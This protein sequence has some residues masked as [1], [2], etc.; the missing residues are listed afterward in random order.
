MARN[1]RLDCVVVGYHDIDFNEYATHQRLM[2]KYSGAYRDV[3]H[4]SVLLNGERITYMDLLNH[5]V[6]TATGANPRFN[7]FE[8]PSLG[9]TYLVSYL[10]QRG[11]GVEMISFFNY[12]KERLAEILAEKPRTVAITTTYYVDPKPII[13]VVEFVRHHSPETTVIVGGPHIYNISCEADLKIQNQ[14]FQSMGA[15]IYIC[16][17]QGENTLTK[18]IEV[19]KNGSDADLAKISNLVY[20]ADNKSFER[21]PRE[22]ENNDMDGDTVDYSLFKEDHIFSNP[23]YLRTAR[24]CPF[25]CSFCNFPT[26]AGDHVITSLEVLEKQFDYL[27]ERGVRDLI[28]IDDTFNV[29]LPR[30]KNLLRMMI[31]NQYDFRWISFFRCSNADDTAFDL[32]KESGCHTVFLGIESGDQDILNNMQKFA[33]IDKYKEGVRKLKERGILTYASIITGFPGETRQTVMN[34]INFIEESAP[35]LFNIQLYYHDLRTPIHKQA[36]KFDITGAGYSW[37]H[38]TMDWQEAADWADFEFTR[39]RNSVPITLYGFSMWCLPYLVGRGISVEKFKEFVGIA[40]GM[41]VDGFDEVDIGTSG[42]EELKML[43]NLFQDMNLA[44]AS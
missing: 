31:K 35:D 12:E 33:K 2:S 27:K 3:K 44:P 4:N 16:D 38:R 23:V 19:V 1:S 28:F 6:E 43:S 39:I 32:M 20:T 21:T 37:R 25:S 29:P 15:D 34:T 22:V 18:V 41:L 42:G 9:V 40:R 36:D 13:G 24:S 26:M 14:I 11:L 5:S 17:S 30:F 7:A 10:R 8:V